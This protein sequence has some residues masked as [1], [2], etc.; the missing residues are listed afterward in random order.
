MAARDRPALY[1]WAI[2]VYKWAFEGTTG[3]HCHDCGLKTTV[4]GCRRQA[5]LGKSD[6]VRSAQGDL[7]ARTDN[8]SVI[9]GFTAE[10]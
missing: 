8:T 5:V 9:P 3:V 4:M 10:R 1:Q 6:P 2:R 7:R